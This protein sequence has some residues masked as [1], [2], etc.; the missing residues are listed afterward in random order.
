MLACHCRRVNDGVIRAA[1]QAGAADLEALAQLCQ[2]G[3]GCGGCHATLEELLRTASTD[4]DG[5]RRHT[6]AA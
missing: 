4:I 1:I 5:G 3:S 6:N 2:A